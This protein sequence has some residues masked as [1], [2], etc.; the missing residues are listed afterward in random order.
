MTG[1]DNGITQV[2]VRT[3][4]N[5]LVKAIDQLSN[6]YSEFYKEVAA[7]KEGIFRKHVY[8]TRSHFSYRGVITSLTGMHEYDEVHLPWS[9]AVSLFQTHLTKKLYDLDFSPAEAEKLLNDYALEY[10]PLLDRLFNELISESEFKG[11]PTLLGRNPS[12]ERG[13]L[14]L[15]FIT[16]IKPDVNDKTISISILSVT[17]F[18]ADFDGDAMYGLLIL[19]NEKARELSHL[20]PHKSTYNL[21]EYREVSPNLSMP[22]QTIATIS[23]WLNDKRDMEQ[24]NVNKTKEMISLFGEG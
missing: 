22:K 6:Y 10:N 3:K 20:A 13:S 1:I 8:G 9:I 7:R 24:V 18:N 17:G 15:F 16:I 5:R 14:Q 12:L 19:D 23:N 11:I 2:S 4:E 21:D